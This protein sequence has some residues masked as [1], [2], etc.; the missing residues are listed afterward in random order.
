MYFAMLTGAC[1]VVTPLSTPGMQEAVLCSGGGEVLVSV[2]GQENMLVRP[3]QDIRPL[4][5]ISWA[6][7]NGPHYWRTLLAP[8]SLI[9]AHAAG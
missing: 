7:A 2:S 5:H 9:K 6:Q 8:W 4:R 3:T 1:L